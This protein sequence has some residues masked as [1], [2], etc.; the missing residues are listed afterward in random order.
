MEGRSIVERA[1]V[2]ENSW[3]LFFQFIN[4]TIIIGIVLAIFYII[5]KLPKQLKKNEQRLEKI[6]N[7]L[8]EINRKIDTK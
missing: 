1:G 7:T 6:E 4:I 3:T 8:N 5:I 2:H